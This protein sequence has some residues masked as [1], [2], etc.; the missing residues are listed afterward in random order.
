MIPLTFFSSILNF[1]AII[2]GFLISALFIIISYG[3]VIDQNRR[4]LPE[5][6]MRRYNKL[7]GEIFS[8]TSFGVLMAFIG[9]AISALMMLGF[10]V[11]I[12]T[13]LSVF[14]I[15]LFIHTLLMV[16][17]RIDRLFRGSI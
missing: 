17:K 12:L 8:N 7:R 5:S 13:A 3:D 11:R 15:L 10:H 16:L 6:E 14:C 2:G 1:Y 9:S 4:R